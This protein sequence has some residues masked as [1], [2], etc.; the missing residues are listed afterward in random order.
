MLL[1]ALQHACHVM[2]SP[3][4]ADEVRVGLAMILPEDD[5][6]LFGTGYDGQQVYEH[7]PG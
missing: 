7:L 3:R 1:S 4:A 2:K 5:A 6:C